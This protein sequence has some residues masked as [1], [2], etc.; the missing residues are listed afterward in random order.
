MLKNNNFKE[1]T[2]TNGG[3]NLNNSTKDGP[4][5]NNHYHTMKY[6]TNKKSEQDESIISRKGAKTDRGVF[7]DSIDNNSFNNLRRES[8]GKIVARRGTAEELGY[9]NNTSLKESS[10]KGY[11]Y[12]IVMVKNK[13]G[14]SCASKNSVA[15]QKREKIKGGKSLENNYYT[16]KRANKNAH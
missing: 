4:I 13:G 8:F 9:D 1:S 3:A 5:T 2:N 7:K 14:D 10:G 11:F 16:I 12:N 15:E 6:S